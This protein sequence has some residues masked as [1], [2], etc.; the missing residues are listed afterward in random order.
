MKSPFT[1]KEMPIVKEWR[2]LNF[3]KDQL[4]ILA[5]FYRCE[6]TGE[7]FEDSALSSLNYN[8]AVNQYRENHCIP[9]P[10]QIAAIRTMY[11][12]SA[13]KMSDI[14]GF[15][16]N[17][18]RQYEAGE[19][20]NQSN[21]KLIQLI[22]D[23][24]EFR[25]LVNLCSTLEQKVKEK[26]NSR[27]DILLNNAK[28]HKHQRQL[29]RYFLD[30]CSPNAYTGYKIP[31]LRKFTEMVVFFS[32]KLKPWKTMLNKLLFYAD[33]EMFRNSGFSISGIQYRALPMGPVPNNYDSIFDYL[34]KNYDIYVNYQYFEG[35][36][37]GEQ[38]TLSEGRLFNCELFSD[39]ELAV[40]ES[41]VSRFKEVSTKD[42]IEISHREKGWL[43]NK[44]D[45]KL[46][47]YLYGFE[48]N[49]A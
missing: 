13:S 12:V 32:E 21:A 25:K 18:Y 38:F 45:R 27:I 6:D 8:Q 24:H 11:D 34:A 30:A 23:P 17:V 26:I 10:E 22:E 44:D 37:T 33:F 19:V 48:L 31:N 15:G 40:L 43:D 2:L 36:G 7:Q 4:S 5:H 46:I 28:A 39:M 16:A 42:I 29:E 47:S 9:F 3:R 35:G 20:P 1:G 49:N 14:L 41:V